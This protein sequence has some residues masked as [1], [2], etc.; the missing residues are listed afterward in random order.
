PFMPC[1]GMQSMDESTQMT[2]SAS[3]SK[4]RSPASTTTSSPEFPKFGI[5]NFELPKLEIPA[6]YREF[7]EKSVSQAKETYEKIRSAADDAT[8]MFEGAYATVSKGVA[9]C[10]LKMIEAARVNTNASFDFASQL[11]AVKSFSEVIELSTAH[12][13]KQFDS[14][15]TQTKD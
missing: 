12:V 8:D 5:P 1:R 6:A 13:R 7:A 3:R 11:M 9:D 10:G 4:S 14:F 2:A 15:S